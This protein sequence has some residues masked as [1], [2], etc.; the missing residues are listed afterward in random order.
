[1][2]ECFAPVEQCLIAAVD[3]LGT[4]KKVGALIWP[5]MDPVEAGKKLSH[6]LSPKHKQRLT[7]DEERFVY[8]LECAQGF[9]SGF[10]QYAE[11]IGWRIERID[12][13]A[14]IAA[15]AHRAER[16]AEA[17]TN[18]SNEVLARMQA[19]GLKVTES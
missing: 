10:Q 4:H 12:T 17:A 11:S 6:C 15:I 1:M 18:L 13:Q 2:A 19:A 9:R 16:M 3:A 8:R 7:Y 5:A 14:E